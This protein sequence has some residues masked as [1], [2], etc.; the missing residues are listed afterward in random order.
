[1]L[2]DQFTAGDKVNPYQL[3]QGTLFYVCH[4]EALA[5]RDISGGVTA[6][7]WTS[8]I[9]SKAGA[10]SRSSSSS[11]SSAVAVTFTSGKMNASLPTMPQT[12][13]VAAAGG[14]KSPISGSKS[15][16]MKKGGV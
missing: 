10:A 7:R 9:A 3:P 15:E 5:R 16:V 4:C 11:S 2:I 8:P 1:M 13:A 12:T 6:P 14:D